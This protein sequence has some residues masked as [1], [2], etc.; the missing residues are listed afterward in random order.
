MGELVKRNKIFSVFFIFPIISLIAGVKFANVQIATK[1]PPLGVERLLSPFWNRL[2]E[3]F[4][5]AGN[6]GNLRLF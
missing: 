6:G 1:S 3:Y 5:V 2:D 4:H